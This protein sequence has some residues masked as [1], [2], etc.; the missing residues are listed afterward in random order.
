MRMK[1]T[2][3]MIMYVV[4]KIYTPYSLLS[5]SICLRTVKC[6]PHL[7]AINWMVRNHYTT[8]IFN[9]NGKCKQRFIILE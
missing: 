4:S 6:P 2:M 9:V 8:Q 7:T 3:L 1:K 5:L